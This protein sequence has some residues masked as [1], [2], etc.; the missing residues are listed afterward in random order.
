[1]VDVL[2]SGIGRFL[3]TV[4]RRRPD[5]IGVSRSRAAANYGRWQLPMIG[6]GL[7]WAGPVPADAIEQTAQAEEAAARERLEEAV[8]AE[9][10][11]SGLPR[12]E[13]VVAEGAPAAN[14]IRQAQGAALLVVGSRGRGGFAGLLLGSVS[15]Q[16]AQ[17]APCPVV[18]VR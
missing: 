5:G 8:A 3:L 17:H 6:G 15:Q 16:C 1:M 2:R 13:I 14:L 12:P 18:I 11:A 10:M 4:A 7:G 9:S